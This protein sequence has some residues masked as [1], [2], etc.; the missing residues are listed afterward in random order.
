[1]FKNYDVEF[2][3]LFW[4]KRF[5]V[6][7]IARRYLSAKEE[8]EDLTQKI[9]LKIYLN[10]GKESKRLHC[11]AGSQRSV[12][13]FERQKRGHYGSSGGLRLFFY[14]ERGC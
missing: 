6:E 1:M 7:K 11:K 3:K 8:V 10:M 9:F 13:L 14:L 4:E 2:E 5:L 12:K